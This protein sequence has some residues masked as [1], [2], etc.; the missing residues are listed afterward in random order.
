MAGS[1]RRTRPIVFAHQ[2]RVLSRHHL[3]RRLLE[4]NPRVGIRE[5]DRGLDPQ[6]RKA[7]AV[8]PAHDAVGEGLRVEARVRAASNPAATASVEL[9]DLRPH[10]VAPLPVSG[11][12]DTHAAGT[13]QDRVQP[14]GVTHR[15]AGGDHQRVRIV[16]D[17]REQGRERGGDAPRPIGSDD[18]QQPR[19]A[20][21]EADRRRG[22]H[23]GRA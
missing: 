21:A 8:S 11:G 10:A 17:R 6:L 9:P 14:D 13:D 23:H 18:A 5:D 20:D 15:E 2:A 19:H 3:V 7:G 22:R 16:E 12:E 4:H 1:R